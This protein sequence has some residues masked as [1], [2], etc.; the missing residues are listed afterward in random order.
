MRGLFAV[1][2]AWVGLLSAPL[3]AQPLGPEPISAAA[4][5]QKAREACSGSATIGS[6]AII[7]ADMDGDGKGDILF[8]WSD[9][10]CTSGGASSVGA[11]FCGMH[12]C[13]IDVY[14]SSQYQP[15]GWPKPIM[16]HMEI[17]PEIIPAGAY[18]MLK[19][20]YQGGS[21]AFAEVCERVWR[22][23]GSKLA[24]QDIPAEDQPAANIMSENSV[25]ITRTNLVGDWVDPADGCA[26]D[27]NLSLRSD[28][29]YGS[30]EEIGDWRLI[31]TRIAIM[32]RETFVM[33]EEGS[34]R[35]VRNPQPV[36]LEVVALTE[37]SMAVRRANG[38]RVDFRK[39]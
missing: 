15:G 36:I 8:N 39:C 13:S 10:T 26:T 5:E 33:G 31:G 2:S 14:L 12:N 25:A 6:G 3:A 37:D 35:R 32:V 17:A 23:D 27:L 7:R 22:W 24:S 1:L 30:Y 34:N 28:G 16:N 9:V 4:L 20:S 11:G 21:C 29:S 38:E 18:P 19:T